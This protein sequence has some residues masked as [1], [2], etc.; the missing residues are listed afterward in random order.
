MSG[1]SIITDTTHGS[2]SDAPLQDA[3]LNRAM[4]RR[5]SAILIAVVLLCEAL[6]LRL[7]LAIGFLVRPDVGHVLPHLAVTCVLTSMVPFALRI[8]SRLGLPGAPLIA[9]KTA[10]EKLPFRI[11]SLLKISAG[12]ALLAL[13]VA[14]SILFVVLVLIFMAH[15][16]SGRMKLP[17]SPM[18]NLAPSRIAIVG[19]LTAIAA[20]ISEEI[21]FR[22]V[23]FAMFTWIARLITRDSFG[24]SRRGVLW[25]VT[26]FQGYVFGMLHMTRLVHTFPLAAS[27]L[28]SIP[29]V[30]V[31]G[32]LLPQ[33]WE[34]I[35]L[36]RLYLRRG[37]EASMLAH[38]MIDAALFVLVAIVMSLRV[39]LGTR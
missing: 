9:A 22:L 13:A 15:P 2:A 32:L 34:G 31:G 23:L 7:A 11:R 4:W 5:E 36:G 39:H 37:L 25:F 3:G 14:T 29:T 35:V 30:L 18:R 20:G 38:A 24:G 10:G 12:Y 16:S 28:H 19:T 21:E 8:N 33:T 6:K 27:M 17:L 26:I 1:E